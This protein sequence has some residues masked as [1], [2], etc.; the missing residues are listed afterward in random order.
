MPQTFSG[1]VPTLAKYNAPSSKHWLRRLRLFERLDRMVE[2]PVVWVSA[3]AGYGKTVLAAHYL[4]ERGRPVLWYRVDGR[5][6]DAGAFFHRLREAASQYEIVGAELLPALTGEYAGGERAFARNFTEALFAGTPDG[7]VLVLDDFQQLPEQASL[8][9]LIPAV[10]DSIPSSRNIFVLSRH[11]PTA[12]MARLRANRRIG[13]LGETELR[14]EAE[15]TAALVAAWPGMDSN[16]FP[17]EVLHLRM[18]GWVAGV[19]LT[20]ERHG[21]GLIEEPVSLDTEVIFDYFATEVVAALEPTERELLLA[22]ALPDQFD[23]ALAHGLR[24][25]SEALS[26]I[27]ALLRRNFFIYQEG[28]AYRYHPLFRDFLLR[29]VQREWSHERLTDTRLQAAQMLLESHEPEMALSLFRDAAEWTKFIELILQLA[30]AMMEQGRYRE[31]EQW[32]QSVPESGF[33]ASSW[34]DFWLATSRL[35]TDYATS[36]TLYSRTY[37]RF[38]EQGDSQGVILAW[39]GAVDAIIFSLSEVSRLD[40]WLQKLE[41]LMVS[42]ATDLEEQL[43]GQLASRII[44]IFTLRQPKH[45]ELQH[46]RAIAE[47]ALD[48]IADTNQRTMSVF[49]LCTHYIWR[50][51]LNQ[52]AELVQCDVS[53]T[54]ESLPPLA[55]ITHTLA[56]AW[57]AWTSGHYDKCRNYFSSGLQLAE[58]TGV[59]VWT[60]VLWLQGVT[61]ALIHG[62]LDEAYD[63]LKQIEPLAVHMRDMDQTYYF[64]DRAWAE[65]SRG[66]K[67]QALLYQRRALQ[68]AD[69]FGAVYSR[70]EANFGMAQV[71][72]ELG[73]EEQALSYLRL[74]EELGELF[75]SWTMSFQCTLARAQ[76]LLSR[77]DRQ[78]ALLPLRTALEQ[79]RI[80]G[81][82]TFNGWRPAVISSLCALALQNGILPDLVLDIIRRYRLPLPDDIVCGNWPWPVKIYTMGSFALEVDGTS[83][84]LSSG[85]HRRPCI[86]L[87]YLIA[88]EPHGIAETALADILWPDA[89]GDMAM[90]NLRTNIFRLRKLLGRSD[91]VQAV[92]GRLKLNQQLC[93]NDTFELNRILLS[94][95]EL[96]DQDALSAITEFLKM[97]GS[98]FLP[99]DEGEL[100]S[101]CR[102]RL[103]KKMSQAIERLAE[104]L[105]SHDQEAAAWLQQL[106]LLGGDTWQ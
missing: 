65:L 86:L 75:C 11:D 61:N 88:A 73:D 87:K 94:I 99:D 14:L 69:R 54:K 5:D 52:A 27:Q 58:E 97:Y 64:I 89:D 34:L 1:V 105:N 79:A 90:R 103:K 35:P 47:R 55:A 17:V 53:R 77:G 6:M 41:P 2:Q 20:L 31:L 74:A 91:A 26:I 23:A 59:Q 93:W 46:W 50:G 67:S 80:H 22:T 102:Y 51:D 25:S 38:K 96:S 62:N 7:F 106:G 100:I 60:F 30:P 42:H 56:Q 37:D 16:A 84:D 76:F 40:A 72:H 4:S 44:T 39:I 36:Y 92:Q 85:K 49:Y 43:S 15:E 29:L 101:E 10:F 83:V 9:A 78:L 81:V 18:Q 57:L 3:P 28:S 8:H 71:C 33:A 70:A 12:G 45:P 98:V 21:E 24:C 95:A 32:L 19:V 104:H 13:V 82:V 63:Y 68:A 66:D 48:G